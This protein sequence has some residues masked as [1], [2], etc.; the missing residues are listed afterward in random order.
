MKWY[1]DNGV[2]RFQMTSMKRPRIRSIMLIL[3]YYGKPGEKILKQIARANPRT[4][5]YDDVPVEERVKALERQ[6]REAREA[7]LHWL[8]QRESNRIR[9]AGLVIALLEGIRSR[10][11]EAV[12]H[13]QY[14]DIYLSYRDDEERK[15]FPRELTIEEQQEVEVL[16]AR[17]R[18]VVYCLLPLLRRKKLKRMLSRPNKPN[19]RMAKNPP[20]PKPILINSAV[21]W[22]KNQ[23]ST[24]CS[25]S[26]QTS[27]T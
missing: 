21:S 23:V 7:Q 17:N 25:A 20:L 24:P 8:L 22:K 15:R 14:G 3:D 19:R 16:P 10:F 13:E 6:L 1:R 11:V 18:V 5:V 27:K 26:R 2:K 4:V 12:Q 9:Q